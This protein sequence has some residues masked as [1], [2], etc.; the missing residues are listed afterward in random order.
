MW[1]GQTE[2]QQR[3]QQRQDGTRAAAA[4]GGG[5]GND[6]RW[7]RRPQTGRRAGG[8][9]GRQGCGRGN[10]SGKCCGRDSSEDGDRTTAA[11]DGSGGDDRRQRRRRQLR[12]GRRDGEGMAGD[13]AGLVFSSGTACSGD[14]AGTEGGGSWAAGGEGGEGGRKR[15]FGA[16]QGDGRAHRRNAGGRTCQVQHTATSFALAWPE[17]AGHTART[18]GGQGHS[19]HQPEI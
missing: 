2:G 6:G 11:A 14:R 9:V 3:R 15:S 19:P 12:T 13:A 17:G 16:W 7:R 4:G 10:G 1:D 18:A 5:G 8:R